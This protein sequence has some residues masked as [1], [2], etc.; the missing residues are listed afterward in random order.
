MVAPVAEWTDVYVASA[1]A[2]AALAGLVFV[3]VS[4]NVERILAFRGLPE[5]GLVTVL[6]LLGAVVASLFGL[7]PDQSDE[8]LGWEILIG[9]CVLSAIVIWLLLKSRPREDEES[10]MA[11]ALGLAAVGTLPYIVAGI[12][13][14]SGSDAGLDWLFSGIVGAIVA[15]VING[16]VLL[17]E[18]L[19]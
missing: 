1:G 11:S 3:A 19:R 8:T 10:H 6:L 7:H 16:W 15:G 18:I 13:L 2:A 9:G 4:I 5:R 17:V 14:V 12:L